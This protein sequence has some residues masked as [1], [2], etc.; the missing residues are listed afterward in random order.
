MAA[1][2]GVSMPSVMQVS[3]P[4]PRTDFTISTIAGMSRSLGLRQ[5]APMQKRFDP[6]SAACAAFCS[7]CCTSISLVASTPLVGAS[8]TGCNSRNPPGNP[9]S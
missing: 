8:P 5:A 4:M 6:A 1:C 2:L 7:T 9:R 3:M